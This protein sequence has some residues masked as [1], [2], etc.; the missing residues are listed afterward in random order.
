MG[1][2][3]S[4]KVIFASVFV[5]WF[6]KFSFF[7]GL[8]NKLIYNDESCKLLKP[9]P[10]EGE[11]IGSEDF[12]IGKHQNVFI[13]Q[14]DLHTAFNEGSYNAKQGHIWYI[15]VE[16]DLEKIIKTTL[17]NYPNDINNFHPHGIYISNITDLLYV[18]NHVQLY[19]GVEIFK[20]D[21]TDSPH[22]ITLEYQHT[23]KSEL[24]KPYAPN[25]VVE[26][27]A[28]GEVYVTQWLPFGYPAGG[29]KHP[30]TPDERMKKSLLVPINA[31]GIKLTHVYLCKWGNVDESLNTCTIAKGSKK[32][33]CANGITISTDRTKL[34]VN[35]LSFQTIHI[36]DINANNDMLKHNGKIHLEYLV[37]NIEYME[38]GDIISGSIPHIYKAIA[39]DAKEGSVEA[40][41]GGMSVVTKDENGNY[42]ETHPM[43]HDGTKLSQISAAV[44]WGG[45]VYLGSPFNEGVLMCKV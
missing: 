1:L 28:K 29:K 44:R 15:N 19:S 8:W 42:V 12:S 5:G 38:N 16:N 33:G 30:A 23:I 24:F 37:D 43:M 27:K 21:Y 14:G 18:T 32:M 6:I 13:T 7:L 35:D 11:M 40:V 3:N 25:D 45:F 10:V 36:Y 4:G 39:N 20:I 31:I 17:K 26:G 41:P 9:P 22:S 34:Y 2:S